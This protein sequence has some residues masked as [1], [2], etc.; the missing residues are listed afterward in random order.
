MS[1]FG[2][3]G[4][5]AP[6][7]SFG[8]LPSGAPLACDHYINIRRSPAKCAKPPGLSPG[9]PRR[10]SGS[11]ANLRNPD[12][13]AGGRTAAGISQPYSLWLVVWNCR[14]R[15]GVRPVTLLNTFVKCGCWVNPA[16][17]AISTIGSLE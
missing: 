9:I 15:S 1:P 6:W 5:P 14:Y 16:S 12:I 2:I 10:P 17:K 13:V 3:R 11:A 4:I 8:F 7:F